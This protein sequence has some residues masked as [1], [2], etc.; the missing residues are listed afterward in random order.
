ML[1]IFS[2]CTRSEE[3]SVIQLRLPEAGTASH[4]V[5]NQALSGQSEKGLP[6]ITEGAEVNCYLVMVSGTGKDVNSC[7]SKEGT[8]LL[9]FGPLRGAVPAGSEL[10][11]QLS[12]SG[13]RILHLVG[14]RAINGACR[15][16]FSH[17]MDVENLSPPRLLD[18]KAIVLK[19]G[20]M[21]VTMLR[22]ADLTQRP[23]LGDCQVEGVS[24][25]DKSDERL[26]R[27]Q[28]FGNGRDGSWNTTQEKYFDAGDAF[29]YFSSYVGLSGTQLS[30]SK[31]FSKTL[32]ASALSPNGDI[33]LSSA[34]NS[35]FLE[36]GDE[37]LW[38]VAAANLNTDPDLACGAGLRRGS[39]GTARIQATP[40]NTRISVS[41]SP[42][43]STPNNSLISVN[44]LTAASSFCRI[45]ITRVPSLQSIVINNNHS[46]DIEAEALNANFEGG[47]L[48]AL[49]V[50]NLS[51]L[52]SGSLTLDADGR[53]FLGEASAQGRS[54]V[55]RRESGSST[56]TAGGGTGATPNGGGGGANA[57]AGGNGSAGGQGG[58][59]I[60]ICTGPCLPWNSKSLFL[61]AAGGASDSIAGADGGGAIFLFAENISGTGELVLSADGDDGQDEGAGAGGSILLMAGTIEPGVEIYMSARGG[62][63][64]WDGGG[65]GGGFVEFKAC[66][67]SANLELSVD[68]GTGESGDPGAV[69]NALIESSYQP[70]CPKP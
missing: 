17:P 37:I 10:S 60:A 27:E 13:T 41:P 16:L 62:I 67:S 59:P 21:R 56:Q 51:L 69:G 46:V 54:S 48:L 58:K 66:N 36:V 55:G 39:W 52:G 7:K 4:L 47:G 44:T 9:S 8:Q 30:S 11:I 20:E 34:Y 2:G 38:W 28:L 40:S 61:G 35:S 68:G 6:S 24:R 32:R 1:C 23:E 14:A 50:R 15:D 26:D 53:G 49:R 18:S 33:D 3:T 43:S 22:P 25:G 12:G 57:G 45:L 65:G 63:G 42:V 5:L 70:L 19:P 31:I 64:E 29:N